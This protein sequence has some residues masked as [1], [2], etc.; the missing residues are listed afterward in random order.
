MYIVYLLIF[1]HHLFF[2]LHLLVFPV[3]NDAVLS[4]S[5]LLI[6]GRGRQG[7]AG[8]QGSHRF[9]KNLALLQEVETQA[10][11]T[12]KNS[13]AGKNGALCREKCSVCGCEI[14]K[15]RSV[16]SVEPSQLT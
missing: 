4:V 14:Y 1:P 8:C 9:L 5:R 3:T 10:I 16:L 6:A 15:A 12:D 7:R 13:S 2:L 11:M